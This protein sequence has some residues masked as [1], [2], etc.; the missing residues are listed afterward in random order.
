M[1]KYLENI[2]WHLFSTCKQGFLMVKTPW[3]VPRRFPWNGYIL[4]LD[5]HTS[6]LNI[7]LTNK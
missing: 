2:N 7:R 5:S 4:L 1:T 3:S 6:D